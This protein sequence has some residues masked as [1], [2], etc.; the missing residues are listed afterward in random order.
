VATLP[1][2]RIVTPLTRDLLD[3]VECQTPGPSGARTLKPVL[4]CG[5]GGM[6]A[7]SGW[8]AAGKGIPVRVG[9]LFI[10]GYHAA[11]FGCVVGFLYER[12]TGEL[13]RPP[14]RGGR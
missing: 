5:I 6:G 8:Y 12:R 11:V 13:P 3:S 2:G 14:R 1:G 10:R 4:A 7:Y 9:R